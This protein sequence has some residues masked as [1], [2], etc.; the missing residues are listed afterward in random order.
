MSF[1]VMGS[2]DMKIEKAN[3]RYIVYISSYH[4]KVFDS[5]KEARKF[6][7]KNKK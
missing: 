5:L 7:K 2:V 4:A 6:I 3:K 1:N